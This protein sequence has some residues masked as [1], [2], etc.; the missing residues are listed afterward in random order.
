M[1]SKATMRKMLWTALWGLF[2]SL[3]FFAWT[4][5]PLAGVFMFCLLAFLVALFLPT[6]EPR[7]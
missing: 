2:A 1:G 3:S 4:S 7:T 6:D 5:N